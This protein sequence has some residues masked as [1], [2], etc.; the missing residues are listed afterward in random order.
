MPDLVLTMRQAQRLWRLDI[1]TSTA[2]FNAL[3]DCR[4]LKRTERGAY[5]RADL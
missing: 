3:L 5:M 1:V 4:F 2:L